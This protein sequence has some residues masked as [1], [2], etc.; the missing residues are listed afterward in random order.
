VAIA[1]VKNLIT[2]GG[3]SAGTT[4]L[5][6]AQS[7]AIDNLLILR[8]AMDNSDSNGA[9]PQVQVTDSKGNTWTQVG[10]GALADP[11]AANAGVGAR[12]FAC[13]ITTALASGDTISV[14]YAGNLSQP[15][16]KGISVDEWSGASAFNITA[17]VQNDV[18]TATP[19]VTCVTVTASGQMVIGHSAV[20]GGTADTITVDA[21]TTNGSWNTLTRVGNGTTT[22][23]ATTNA[24]YKIVNASGN[25]TY[26]PTLG[27]VRDNCAQIIR[28]LPY[29]RSTKTHSVDASLSATPTV[30]GQMIAVAT[31]ARIIANSG[32]G[33]ASS[34]SVVAPAVTAVANS[35]LVGIF[36]VRSASTGM[37]VASGMTEVT[38][39][40]SPGNNNIEVATL[41]ASAGSTG[42]KTATAQTAGPNV[43]QLLL[44][45]NSTLGTKTHSVNA[46]IVS[47]STKTHQVNALVTKVWL[48]QSGV[49]TGNIA[50]HSSVTVTLPNNPT[51]GNMFV[52]TAFSKSTTNGVFSTV[53]N[54]TNQ[55]TPA[56]SE[57]QWSTSG[58]FYTYK[59]WYSSNITGGA[60]TIVSVVN[61]TGVSMVM[62]LIVSEWGGATN[63]AT[64]DTITANTASTASTVNASTG[65]M[66]AI[67]ELIYS[68]LLHDDGSLTITE[69]TSDTFASV[70]EVETSG[71]ASQPCAAQYRT[72]GNTTSSVTA[73]WTT[74]G[75]ATTLATQV[76][77]FRPTVK[78]TYD[79]DAL[80]VGTKKTHSVDAFITS[81]RVIQ[82]KTAT[83]SSGTSISLT[84]DSAP[85]AGNMLVAW[86]HSADAVGT[87]SG[88][89]IWTLA[90]SE[91]LGGSVNLLN[92]KAYMWYRVADIGENST[93]SMALASDPQE[94]AI[95]VVELSGVIALNDASSTADSSPGNIS[96]DYSLPALGAVQTASVAL[97]GA[98]S[99][100]SS[101]NA[102]SPTWTNGFK[103]YNQVNTPG[104]S[105]YTTA[106]TSFVGVGINPVE[107]TTISTTLVWQ[108]QAY[109]N[110]RMII[111]VFTAGN[112]GLRSHSVDAFLVGTKKTHSVDAVVVSR[113]TKT[114]NVDASITT[115]STTITIT[116]Q[117]DAIIV[118]TKKTYSVDAYI[119]KIITY[120]VDALVILRFTKTHQVDA[121]LSARLTKTHSVDAIIKK[122]QTVIHSTDAVL[123]A[124]SIRTHSV[125]AILLKT[126]TLTHSVDSVL[127][128]TQT[129]TYQIDAVLVGTKITYSVDAVLRKTQ[130]LTHN[131]DA[132]IVGTKVT[133]QIDAVLLKTRTLTH[134]SDAILKA[135]FTRTHQV[136]TVLL[137]TRTL[138]HQIDAILKA[139]LTRTHQ[140]DA[141]LLKT[142]TVSHLIDAALFK[143][144]QVTH[145]VDTIVILR[146]IKTHSVDAYIKAIQNLTHQVDAIVVARNIKTHQ[147]DSFLLKTRQLTHDVDAGLQKTRTLTHNV[148]A[149]L[150]K[151]QTLSHSIDAALRATFTRTYQTDAILQKT[152][153]LTY[154]VDAYISSRLQLTHQVDSLLRATFTRTYSVDALVVSRLIKTH[155]VDAVLTTTNQLTYQVDALLR[156]TQA[157]TYQV[158][159]V[160]QATLTNTHQVD[161][162]LQLTQTHTYQTDAV[163][164]KTQA[165]SHSV[166]AYII[167]LNGKAHLVDAV[168][169]A[170]FVRTYSG[171]AYVVNRFT[172]SYATDAVLRKT[173]TAQHATDALLLKLR[174]LTHQTDAVLKATQTR[175]HSVDAVLQARRTLIYSVDAIVKSIAT[176]TYQVNA[177]LLKTQTTTYSV[178]SV[179][180]AITSQQYSVDAVV[181]ATRTASHQV[182]AVIV[183]SVVICQVDAVLSRRLNLAHS[184]DA[185]VVVAGSVTYLVDAAIVSSP[186]ISYGVD[187]MIVQPRKIIFI[188]TQGPIL[189]FTTISRDRP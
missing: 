84:L 25:Q 180:K 162:L 75:T 98:G 13:Q 160:L 6:L 106:L 68:T 56:S 35:L 89:G 120:Q 74:S 117:V 79:L 108:T 20:E 148:D 142:S 138:T 152:Q 124:S 5:T 58:S 65:T 140:V 129:R 42:T 136:D 86:A 9:N 102:T 139:T 128:K 1:F 135:T 171:D 186:V 82:T 182:D 150:Q 123:K 73:D 115:A 34:T 3:T 132:I 146:S 185:F 66:S 18:T 126:Q 143:T 113:L 118:G 174:T 163:L 26:N 53:I 130:I 107:V 50:H 48:V 157:L 2:G 97:G 167:T 46:A 32:Q 170:T 166:D 94:T 17:V 63:A 99:P 87:P 52:V 116:H 72:I 121:Y 109:L 24:Q 91:L 95:G 85:T 55:F 168:L 112:R 14:A 90:D 156:K 10:T 30:L 59:T 27:T 31:P 45:L 155:Q 183:K 122:T 158:D 110:R 119:V 29:T 8:V 92:E 33:N 93:I 61:N 188:I 67:N 154:D 100:Q 19:S 16:A 83:V 104:N 125:D 145:S 147:V 70:R 36:G 179:L 105:S 80:I 49:A 161:A 159:A 178:D 88:S 15:S 172:R 144:Q 133:Y 101:A 11:G 177:V 28:V 62:T 164:R 96:V 76:L 43:G 77:S 151:T 21:D 47:T 60:N 51:S 71:A 64:V 39:F 131:V 176:R 165:V 187:T 41:A 103:Q 22:S 38:D 175:T 23:G 37:T 137:K 57:V 134:Q 184:V 12:I 149:V 40:D 78:K 141:I 69:D 7:A 111:S 4:T 173:Q 114:H 81:I 169:T 181:R 189:N 127:K 54:G 44:L 153:S